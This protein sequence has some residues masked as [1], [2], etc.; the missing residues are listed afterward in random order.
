MTIRVGDRVT[1]TNGESTLVGE[2]TDTSWR[3]RIRVRV[4]NDPGYI[5]GRNLYYSAWVI[6]KELPAEPKPGTV[7]RVEGLEDGNNGLWLYYKPGEDYPW[8]FINGYGSL[9]PGANWKFLNEG[10]VEGLGRS[11]DGE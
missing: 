5:G 2:V 4:D 8:Y 9:V 10:T 3:D 1:A 11:P 6:Q 7:V